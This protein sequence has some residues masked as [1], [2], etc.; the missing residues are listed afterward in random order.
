[1]PA[2]SDAPPRL[3][4][5]PPPPPPSAPAVIPLAQAGG[6]AGG[7]STGSGSSSG[8]AGGGSSSGGSSG[9]AGGGDKA[10]HPM[11]IWTWAYAAFLAGGPCDTHCRRTCSPRRAFLQSMWQ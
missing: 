5:Y 6:A 10:P 11:R 9:A 1:M 8:G 7:G 2:L 3:R 4:A